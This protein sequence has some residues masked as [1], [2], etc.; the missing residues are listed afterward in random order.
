MS[1]KATLIVT[2][3]P[4]PNEMEAL[5]EYQQKA[6]A[7]LEG[8]GGKNLQRYE[9]QS[10]VVG[11]ARKIVALLDFESTDVIEGI[12]N[13]PE[14]QAIIPLRDKGFANLEIHIGKN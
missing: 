9:I 1:D 3:T 2:A 14:Y 13:S 8:G 11:G 6:T 10:S 5:K 4:N 12:L 7:L